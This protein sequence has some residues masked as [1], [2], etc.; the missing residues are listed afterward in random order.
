MRDRDD[1]GSCGVEM[2][3]VHLDRSVWKIFCLHFT[4]VSLVLI[5]KKYEIFGSA[6]QL[7]LTDK[8]IFSSAEDIKVEMRFTMKRCKISEEH[9]N[10]VR[11]V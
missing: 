8:T 9:C 3:E 11:K 1:F 4:S 2:L 5:I 10:L 6:N 7:A